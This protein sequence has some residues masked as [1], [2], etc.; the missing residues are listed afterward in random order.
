[1]QKLE[2]LF[3]ASSLSPASRVYMTCIGRDEDPYIKHAKGLGPCWLLGVG[4]VFKDAA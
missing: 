1:M 3:R 2:E 4:D